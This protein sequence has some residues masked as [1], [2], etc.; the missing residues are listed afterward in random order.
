MIDVALSRVRMETNAQ[1]DGRTK[2]LYESQ[3]KTSLRLV[4][5][6][7]YSQLAQLHRTSAH[8]GRRSLRSDSLRSDGV[9]GVEDH[10]LALS[11][12]S[13][14]KLLSRVTPQ[15]CEAEAVQPRSGPV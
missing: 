7:K 1:T 6:I 5:I 13:T 9:F 3:E 11:R 2:F 8:K 12:R 10:S 14:P 4:L 15:R